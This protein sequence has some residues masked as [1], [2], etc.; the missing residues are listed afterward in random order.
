MTDQNA[1]GG[2]SKG[3]THLTTADFQKTLDTAGMPVLV[4]FYAD[5]CGPCKIAAP[6][7]D[8]LAEVYRGKAVVAKLNTDDHSEIAQ[9]FGV[10][11]IPTVI[12]FGKE[13]ASGK[14]QELKRQVGLLNKAGYQQMIDDALQAAA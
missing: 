14:V 7:I 5:W 8:E 10:M 2:A 6:I 3:A 11:S 1:M 12:V 13:A 4:D 9:K